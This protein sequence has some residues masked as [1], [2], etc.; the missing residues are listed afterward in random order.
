MIQVV[1]PYIF[2]L[3]PY[4]QVVMKKR[5]RSKELNFLPTLQPISMLP[6]RYCYYVLSTLN[7]KPPL[8]FDPKCFAHYITHFQVWYIPFNSMTIL[9]HVTKYYIFFSS[10][11]Y[12][13]VPHVVVNILYHV[14][15][16]QCS[17]CHFMPYTI[18]QVVFNQVPLFIHTFV[19]IRFLGS[20]HMIA[21]R[22]VGIISLL[23]IGTR[24]YGIVGPSSFFTWIYTQ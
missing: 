8:L 15:S 19:S 14:P 6:I 23:I 22:I 16:S 4:N 5:K 13:Q 10:K 11:P 12:N 7:V 21:C 1:K 3:N 20:N 18:V 9:F 24:I 2:P 17:S